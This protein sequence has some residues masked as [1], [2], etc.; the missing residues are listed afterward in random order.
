MKE[1]ARGRS[2]VRALE[3]SPFIDTADK[4]LVG[5]KVRNTPLPERWVKKKES[6]NVGQKNAGWPKRVGP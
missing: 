5:E 4:H 3:P 1:A 2:T 6:E